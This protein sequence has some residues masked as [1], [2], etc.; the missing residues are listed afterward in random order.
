[1]TGAEGEAL[2]A[3]G[4]MRVIHE[5]NHLLVVDKPAGLL[6]QSASAGDDNLVE[7]AKAYLKLKHQKPGNVYLGLVHRL[8]RNVSGVLIL[9]KTSKAAARLTKSFKDRT[10]EKRYLALVEGT[11]YQG[12]ELVHHL[13]PRPQ[14]RG[15]MEA[16]QGKRASLSFRV[17]GESQKRSLLEV[18]LHT[19]RKHQIRAQLALSDMPLV[20]DPLYGHRSQ[21]MR[22]P[23]L[24]AATLT[25]NHPVKG[26]GMSFKSVIPRDLR[27]ALAGD[28]LLDAALR[29]LGDE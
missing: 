20:G 5:D 10:L 3:L 11:G 21:D 16:P 17:L 13:G 4:E 14:G 7:R 26:E 18:D 15:V 19:G 25:I 28:N 24:L 12:R 9:A 1:V 6:S 23:A 22:R 27:R 2:K 8:D 29:I